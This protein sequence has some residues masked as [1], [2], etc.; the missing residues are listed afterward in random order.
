MAGRNLL[1]PWTRGKGELD[2]FEALHRQIDRAFD[3]VWRGFDLAPFGARFGFGEMSPSLDVSETETEIHVSAEL[4]GLDEKDI[5]VELADDRLTIKGEKKQEKEEK[6][7]NYFLQER[8]Y[9]SFQRTVQLPAGVDA[10][11]TK[12]SFDKGVLTVTVPKTAAARKVKKVAIKA[13]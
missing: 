4:P 3:D 8:T 7:K 11:K 9:G 6:K 10:G 1:T 13:R 12:A 5:E 2:P